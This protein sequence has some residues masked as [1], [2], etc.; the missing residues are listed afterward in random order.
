[1]RRAEIVFGCKESGVAE[2]EV[3]EVWFEVLTSSSGY[4]LFLSSRLIS[5]GVS[6]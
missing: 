6:F 5:S 3:L 2:N 4:K 1:M